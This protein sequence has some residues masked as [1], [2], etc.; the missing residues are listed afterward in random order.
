[1]S[2]NPSHPLA[3]I[4]HKENVHHRNRNTKESTQYFGTPTTRAISNRLVRKE[5]EESNQQYVSCLF[6]QKTGTEYTQKKNQQ[7]LKVKI[8]ELDHYRSIMSDL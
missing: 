5:L 8:Q 2:P 4:K 1:M 6:S 7:E 3:S